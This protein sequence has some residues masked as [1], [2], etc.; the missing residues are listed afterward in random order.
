MNGSEKEEKTDVHYRSLDGYGSFNWR[1]VLDFDFDI[2]EKKIAIYKKKRLF[3]CL[4]CTT[5]SSIIGVPGQGSL[6]YSYTSGNCSTP[7]ICA[8]LM[9]ISA[10][11]NTQKLSQESVKL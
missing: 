8:S 6:K 5:D 7:A 3:R 4:C 2:W 11:S 1:F 10:Y 9:E